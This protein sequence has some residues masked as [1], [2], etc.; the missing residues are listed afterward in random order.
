MKVRAKFKVDSVKASMGSVRDEEGNWKQGE[1]RTVQLFPVSGDG[2]NE[3]FWAATP[4][5]SIELGCANLEAAKA[6]EL[7]QE[8]YVDFTP[9]PK[10]E[11]KP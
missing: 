11:P 3:K 2:E 1:V 5:G 8:Y 4:S 7:G 6:F 10:A 9:A